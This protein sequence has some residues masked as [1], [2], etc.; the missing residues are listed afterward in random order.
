MGSETS[1][2]PI[3]CVFKH[4]PGSQS[5]TKLTP[6]ALCTSRHSLTQSDTVATQSDTVQTPELNEPRDLCHIHAQEE[7][8]SKHVQDKKLYMNVGQPCDMWVGMLCGAGCNYR[9]MVC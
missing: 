7:L 9:P 6:A 2:G 5:R 4:A 1:G 8:P 3:T